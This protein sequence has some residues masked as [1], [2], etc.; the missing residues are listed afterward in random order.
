MKRTPPTSNRTDPLLPDTQ[1]FRWQRTR[2]ENAGDRAVGQADA[3][4]DAGDDLMWNRFVLG[5]H[6]FTLAFYADSMKGLRYH[7][8]VARAA[9]ADTGMVAAREGA[10]L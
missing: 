7:M 10:A 1:V 4:I 6:H 8:S 2:M 5:D 3:V 9:L